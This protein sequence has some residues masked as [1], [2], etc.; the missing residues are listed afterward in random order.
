MVM[1]QRY[2][3]GA[4]LLLST[5]FLALAGHAVAQTPEPDGE[6]PMNPVLPIV[7]DIILPLPWH[8]SSC[9]AL[10]KSMLEWKQG[11]TF[12]AWHPVRA[13]VTAST[14]TLLSSAGP[15][16]TTPDRGYLT[17][18]G[19]N[20]DPHGPPHQS[21]DINANGMAFS[22]VFR[23]NASQPLFSVPSTQQRTQFSITPAGQVTRTNHTLPGGQ[24]VGVPQS[25]S[26]EC[27]DNL[28]YGSVGNPFVGYTSYQ[29]SF[30][31]A[32]HRNI[33]L[34]PQ[35]QVPVPERIPDPIPDPGPIR[36]PQV[37]PF[38]G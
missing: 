32:L 9:E 37:S 15:W 12:L 25:G 31:K 18:Y 5:G 3:T 33:F 6:V 22:V 1:K 8:T 27:R 2:R 28:M 29:M 13:T 14:G 38:S 11:S 24:Q 16:A 4:R 36:I 34:P 35:L 23:N 10:L 7:D 17:L 21:I 30:R 26:F 20:S 19:V